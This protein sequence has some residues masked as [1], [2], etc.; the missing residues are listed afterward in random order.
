MLN[1]NLPYAPAF[2]LIDNHVRKKNLL[3]KSFYTDV[4]SNNI[5]N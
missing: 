5:A 2:P 4:Y 1:T 3:Y